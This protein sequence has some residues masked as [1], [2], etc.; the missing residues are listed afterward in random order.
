MLCTISLKIL[1]HYS[2]LCWHL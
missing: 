1:K 2:L